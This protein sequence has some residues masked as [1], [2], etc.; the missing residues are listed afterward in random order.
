MSLPLLHTVPCGRENECD[1]GSE[2]RRGDRRDAAIGFACF[3][4]E[5]VVVVVVV[6]NSPS[7][8][9]PFPSA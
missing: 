7:E 2:K 4:G 3:K 9:A 6:V 8:G 1:G 5:V